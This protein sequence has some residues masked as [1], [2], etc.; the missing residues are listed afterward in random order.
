MDASELK[1]KIITNVDEDKVRAI[2]NSE[3]ER[4]MDNIT[5]QVEQHLV[6]NTKIGIV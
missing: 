4:A 5:K 6:E 2:I 1:V 3:F